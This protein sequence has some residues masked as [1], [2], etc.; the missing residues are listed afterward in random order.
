MVASSIRRKELI[1]EAT[2]LLKE[3]KNQNVLPEAAQEILDLLHLRLLQAEAPQ[4][5]EETIQAEAKV[6]P[7]EGK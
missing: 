6:V 1:R 4:K 7:E 5:V 3:T 2:R